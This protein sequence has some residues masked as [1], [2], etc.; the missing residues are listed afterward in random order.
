MEQVLGYI[1]G[2]ELVRRYHQ[3]CKERMSS[4]I[5]EIISSCHQEL[6]QLEDSDN[7]DSEAIKPYKRHL[8]TLARKSKRFLEELTKEP[9][10]KILN[11]IRNEI[12]R[13]VHSVLGCDCQYIAYSVPSSKEN[14][15]LLNLVNHH[16]AYLNPTLNEGTYQISDTKKFSPQIESIF[17]ETL[18]FKNPEGFVQ[19]LH[20]DF[21]SYL[22][23]HSPLKTRIYEVYAKDDG[24]YMKIS[25]EFMERA[26]IS[27][28]RRKEEDSKPPNSVVV[29]GFESKVF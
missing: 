2:E 22:K 18:P 29:E 20:S 21:F 24:I 7:V 6:M 25:D 8:K 26:R 12:P 10:E 16:F 4:Q 13:Q 19:F 28:E 11:I 17:L 15:E 5:D 1:P 9:T 27:I 14:D 23:E 3:N